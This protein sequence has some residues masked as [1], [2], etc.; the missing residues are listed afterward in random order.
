M[1]RRAFITQPN[2]DYTGKPAIIRFFD[3]AK[4]QKILIKKVNI[5]QDASNTQAHLICFS[6]LKV[7]SQSIQELCRDPQISIFVSQTKCKRFVHVMMPIN[8]VKKQ[9][10]RGL[11]ELHTFSLLAAL[12]VLHLLQT[13][14]LC[15]NFK[16][17]CIYQELSS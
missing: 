6:G 15:N 16:I 10:I 11:P 17:R 9:N 1:C 2:T 13:A 3:A 12:Y 4:L 8:N 14:N 5:L 7:A